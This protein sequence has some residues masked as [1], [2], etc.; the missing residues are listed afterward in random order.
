MKNR[1]KA[2][3]PR[4]KCALLSVALLL[5][6]ALASYAAGNYPRPEGEYIN[7]FAG[8]LTKTDRDTL[9]DMLKKLEAKSGIRMNVVTVKSITEYPTGDPDIESFA[10][11][12]FGAWGL[13]K[14][15]GVLM[16][17][18]VKDRKMRIELGQGYG[19][20]YEGIMKRLIDKSMLPY[21]REGDYSRGIYEGVRAVISRVTRKLSIV[22]LYWPYM[23]A[24]LGVIALLAFAMLGSGK[25]AAPKQK[26]EKQKKQAVEPF[27]KGAWG[28]W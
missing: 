22:E 2:Q 26:K 23:A 19:E 27:G 20:E 24:G 10:A 11:G 5:S 15:S 25:G 8:T 21:F 4:P 17:V 6:L 1:P 13:E 18:A 12:L 7:D 9:S 16:L 28:E 3:V 14:D